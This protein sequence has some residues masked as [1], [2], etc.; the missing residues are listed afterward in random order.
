V[1]SYLSKSPDS[2]SS[3]HPRSYMFQSGKKEDAVP[4]IPALSCLG[5]ISCHHFPVLHLI[6]MINLF[7]KQDR[8][9]SHWTLTGNSG[10]IHLCSLLFDF[11]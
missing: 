10:G 3:V 5:L 11:R 1:S 9:R 4:F 6:W 8:P 2:Q 7:K